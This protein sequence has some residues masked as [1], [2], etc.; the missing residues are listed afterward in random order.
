MDSAD[1]Q[2]LRNA[3]QSEV[4]ER[5][6]QDVT[7]YEQEYKDMFSEYFEAGDGDGN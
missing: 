3:L 4:E 5:G 1:Q 6:L 7:N 2:S